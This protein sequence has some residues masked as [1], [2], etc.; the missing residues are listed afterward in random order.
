[1]KSGELSDFLTTRVHETMI[2]L[3]ATIRFLGWWMI[4]I[5]EERISEEASDTIVR[6]LLPFI[7]I[8]VC[9]FP[10]VRNAMYQFLTFFCIGFSPSSAFLLPHITVN[11]LPHVLMYSI[12]TN[13][14]VNVISHTKHII[15]IF[16]VF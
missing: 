11:S 8:L 6:K 2:V 14:S 3:Q 12:L 15:H 16:F 9:V 10:T 13:I 5:R 7:I 4:E 1:M